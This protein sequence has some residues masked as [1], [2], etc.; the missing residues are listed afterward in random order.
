MRFAFVGFR[1]GHILS[2]YKHVQQHADLEVAAACEE[3]AETREDLAAKGAAEVTHTSY[4]DMLDTVD[5]DAVAV[6]DY[7]GRRGEVAIEALRRG[8]HVIA[9]K[10]LCTSLAEQDEIERLSRERGL[11]VGCMLTMRGSAVFRT[12]RTLILGG[13]IGGVH[14]ISFGGQHPLNYGSRPSWYFEPGKHGGTIT[15]IGIHAL[16][17]IPW[18]TGMGFTTVDAARNWNARLKQAPHFKDAA[19]M[20]LTMSNGCGVLGDV[21]YLMPDK[22]G[23]AS[24]LYWRMTFWGA[25]GVIEASSQA[26]AVTLCRSDDKE[27]RRVELEPGAGAG[28]LTAFC[29]QIAGQEGELYISTE[30]CLRAS[31]TALTVQDAADRG[32]HNVPLPSATAGT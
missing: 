15:D 3:H 10:P 8:R 1:H 20:M 5:C 29:Q 21:S 4:I 18:M 7:Y 17:A 31:R 23:Y 26:K 16:D 27:P 22:M 2:L 28:Y 13:E 19:Q 6:G 25:N 24:T 14:A 30:E 32:L 11:V 9:D 12:M